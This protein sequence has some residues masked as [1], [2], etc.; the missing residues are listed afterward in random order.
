MLNH[1][2]GKCPWRRQLHTAAG[3]QLDSGDARIG[4]PAERRVDDSGAAETRIEQTAAGES[5]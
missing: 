5:S 4:T 2:L 3:I 1:V